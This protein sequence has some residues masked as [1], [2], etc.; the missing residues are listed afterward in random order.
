M[1]EKLEAEK[2]RRVRNIFRVD[3]WRIPEPRVWP[4]ATPV[5]YKL[6]NQTHPRLTPIHTKQKKT[7]E[8]RAGDEGARGAAG[9]GAVLGGAGAVHG[10]GAG[11]QGE[12]GV[13]VCLYV[14]M[15]KGGRGGCRCIDFDGS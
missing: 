5:T 14:G 11:V 6:S 15:V 4:S 1:A 2:Q 7:G 13:W 8:G 3:L 12:G 9:P 10:A